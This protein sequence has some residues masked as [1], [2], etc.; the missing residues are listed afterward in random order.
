MRNGVLASGTSSASGDD[1]LLS[2]A[3]YGDVNCYQECR[4]KK[5]IFSYHS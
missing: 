3:R 5:R 2:V 4:R 1:K